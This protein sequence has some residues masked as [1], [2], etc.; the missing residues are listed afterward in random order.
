[1][2]NVPFQ[3]GSTPN[4]NSV[5]VSLTTTISPKP[6]TFSSASQAEGD[7]L[8]KRLFAIPGVT[9]VFMLNNFVSINKE[10]G[11]DWAKIEPKIAQI[12]QDHFHA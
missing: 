12:F 8:A 4:P 2:A 6:V 3:I 10:P 9:M 5:R 7:P 1:M 11:A